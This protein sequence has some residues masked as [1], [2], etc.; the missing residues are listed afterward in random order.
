M[1]GII[2]EPNGCDHRG[3]SHTIKVAKTGRLTTCNIKHIRT[4]TISV[5]H[6]L[7]EQ[8]RKVTGQL[9]KVQ[10]LPAEGDGLPR[11]WEQDHVIGVT[12]G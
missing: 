7:C 11:Q 12:Q 10:P 6:Y 2:V 4:T 1:H 8:I 3:C 5:E 9:E